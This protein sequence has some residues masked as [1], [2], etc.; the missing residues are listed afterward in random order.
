MKRKW[1]E[2]LWWKLMA[3]PPWRHLI[4][5][6]SIVFSSYQLRGSFPICEHV[7]PQ[8]LC[9]NKLK[10]HI[11]QNPFDV[12]S[13]P[14]TINAKICNV[15][16]SLSHVQLSV[17][18]C[19]EAHQAS[20]SLLS[21]WVCSNSCPLSQWCHPTISSCVPPSP[22]ALCLSQYQ[23]PFQWVGSWYQVVKLLEL[24]LQHQSLQWIF[25]VNFL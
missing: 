23:G 5:L 20:L 21:P 4:V 16:Q 25:R 11:I 9:L 18:P 22:P 3:S 12:L 15:V 17:T 10:F 24:Q 1:G 2:R 8:S 13:L 19:S 7:V 6:S 14:K